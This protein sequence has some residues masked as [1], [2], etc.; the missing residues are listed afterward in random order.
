MAPETKDV[1]FLG[2]MK[3][4]KELIVR[5]KKNLSNP[6]EFLPLLKFRN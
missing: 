2:Q 6:Y 4:Y 1:S 3:V 5:G